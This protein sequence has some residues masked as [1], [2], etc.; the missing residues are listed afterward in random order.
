MSQLL[1]SAAW[2]SP[3]WKCQYL[4]EYSV[5]NPLSQ[6][7]L[8]AMKTFLRFHSR[9][10]EGICIMLPKVINFNISDIYILLN[11]FFTILT[12]RFFSVLPPYNVQCH[13][14]HSHHPHPYLFSLPSC[15]TVGSSPDLQLSN[16][17]SSPV[18]RTSLEGK[19]DYMVLVA[20]N[21]GNYFLCLM[22]L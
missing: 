21:R 9:D 5:E 6:K 7:H 22:F 2:Y 20:R 8:R 18:N 15:Y 4:I 3:R 19:W 17:K 11:P 16:I 12:Q 14:L 10:Q 13:W 1:S